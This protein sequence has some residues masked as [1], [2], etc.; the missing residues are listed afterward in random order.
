[1]KTLLVISA[2]LTGLLIF[3]TVVCGLWLRY[4]GEPVEQS[5]LNFH[6]IIGLATALVACVT[7]ILG[8]ASVFR[9]GA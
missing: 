7:V 6:M 5:S 4:S 2:V 9:G 1:M 8:V 3:S